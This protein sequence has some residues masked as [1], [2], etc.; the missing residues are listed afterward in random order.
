MPWPAARWPPRSEALDSAPPAR[1][2]W[3]A[4]GTWRSAGSL[5]VVMSS[6]RR[7]CR[8][9]AGKWS[10]MELPLKPG[11]EP[12]HTTTGW[13]KQNWSHTTHTKVL[14]LHRTV[15]IPTVQAKIHKGW[16]SKM[17]LSALNMFQWRKF[18]DTMRMCSHTKHQTSLRRRK[19]SLTV[20]KIPIDRPED[21]LHNWQNSN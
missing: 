14:L 20:Y 6:S 21:G 19:K 1:S 2:G 8:T 16:N 5:W 4:S 9:P 3:P 18:V 15:V 11:Q 10:A 7:C 12:P 13:A 17:V